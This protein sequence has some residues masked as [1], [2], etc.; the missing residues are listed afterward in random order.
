M[1]RSYTVFDVETPNAANDRMCSIGIT[2]VDGGRITSSRNILVDP[3]CR[4]DPFNISIHGIYPEDVAGAE[5]FPAVWAQLRPLFYNRVVVA[6]NACFD[7]G[8]LR[9]C[10]AFYGMTA[11]PVWYLDTV[12]AA[13]RVYPDLPNHKLNTLCDFLAIPLHHHDSGSDCRATAQLL[14]DMLQ[15]GM[16]AERF[17]RPYRMDSEST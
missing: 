3:Q 5:T 4:F 7:L 16:N 2:T 6:H 13:R 12:R 14:L 10:L 11:E 17:L 15:E 8:V 1:N 9:K